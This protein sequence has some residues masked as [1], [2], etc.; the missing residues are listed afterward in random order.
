MTLTK[1]QTAE[2]EELA[3]PVVRWLRDNGHPMCEVVIGQQ[4]LTVNES[5]AGIP[6]HQFETEHY[7]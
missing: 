4:H 2:L 3:K 7:V 6:Y 5:I 1:E